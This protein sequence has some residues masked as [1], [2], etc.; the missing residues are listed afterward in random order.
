MTVLIGLQFMMS[1][2]FVQPNNEF[3][4][5]LDSRVHIRSVYAACLHA[6]A[7]ECSNLVAW[8]MLMHDPTGHKHACLQ[9]A[10]P[11]TCKI[12]LACTV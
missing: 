5:Q 8:Q 3:S 12:K 7:V 4:K 2:K 10:S 11:H 6:C 1:L 9:M